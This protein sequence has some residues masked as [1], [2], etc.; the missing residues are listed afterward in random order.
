MGW[1]G[2]QEC[3][4]P[5]QS[6]WE[7]P[8]RQATLESQERDFELVSRGTNKYYVTDSGGAEHVE[9]ASG[10]QGLDLV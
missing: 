4:I 6:G 9:L 8:G 1:E 7:G 2:A 5:E 3:L 10:A